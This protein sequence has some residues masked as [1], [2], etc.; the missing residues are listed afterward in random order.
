MVT[1][2]PRRQR[3]R[4]QGQPGLHSKFQ[5]SHGH[6]ERP[7]LKNKERWGRQ[8]KLAEN[9][10]APVSFPMG[11]DCYNSCLH[12]PTYQHCNLRLDPMSPAAFCQGY[13]ITIEVKPGPWI[14]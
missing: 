5:D 11:P 14:E 2:N 6:K 7:C 3:Q 10:Q 8:R 9:K 1:F 12:F 4:D 13:F